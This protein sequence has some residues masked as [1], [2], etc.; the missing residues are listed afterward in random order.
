MANESDLPYLIRLLDDKD[1]AVRPV[2]REHL[3][4]F[5]GDI[6]H[7]LAALGIDI[8]F[9]GKKR[10]S[11]LLSPGR[12]ET[13]RNEWVVPTAGAMAMEDDWENFENTLRQIS[14]F[15]HDGITLRPSLSDSLDLLME[16]VLDDHIAPTANELRCWLFV[17][18]P[19]KGVGDNTTNT[20]E[21]ENFD[22]CHVINTHIGN[23]TSLGCLFML[24][25]RRM[26]VQVDGCNY[27]E[28][29]LARIDV[30]G[31]A[32]LIDCFHGGRKFDID[33]L[34]EAHP[35]ISEKARSAVYASSHLGV[36]LLRFVREMQP[37]FI[38]VKR[39]ED[40]ALFVELAKTLHV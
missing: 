28:H 37:S 9:T 8:N 11:R 33:S 21:L 19:F 13:L 25:G 31:R 36:I 29:F 5:G 39:T 30:E 20:T 17:D 15:L 38:A 24:L 16:E 6:S 7:D 35:E 1:P 2:V 18:G 23:A 22:L 26:G 12:R 10:L 14:D 4:D 32:Q 3:S 40:A 27:P 34:I